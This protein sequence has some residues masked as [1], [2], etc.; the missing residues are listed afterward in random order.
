MATPKKTKSAAAKTAKPRKATPTKAKAAKSKLNS[1][2]PIVKAS[3]DAL[4]KLKALKI[5]P[6]LQNDIQ[7]CLG[8]YAYDKNPTGL[9]EMGGKAL[10]VFKD[11]KSINPKTVPA[12][13]LKNLEKALTQ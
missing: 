4:K 10:K 12:T 11:L 1:T 5:E 3:E 7:W 8:S 6:G 13:L 2:L 9:F